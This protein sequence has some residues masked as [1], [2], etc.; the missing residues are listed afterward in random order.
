MMIELDSSRPSPRHI[1]FYRRTDDSAPW[2]RMLTDIGCVSQPVIDTDGSAARRVSAQWRFETAEEALYGGGSHQQN[3]INYRGAALQLVQQNTESAVP[4]FTSS[5]G[6][7]LL[8]DCTS[9]VWLNPLEPKVRIKVNK[10]ALRGSVA[11]VPNTTGRHHVT[12]STGALAWE[13]SFYR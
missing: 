6:F 11:F 12:A 9:E 2:E 8:W 1:A 10:S 13:G 7:G 3:L 4:F 5:A